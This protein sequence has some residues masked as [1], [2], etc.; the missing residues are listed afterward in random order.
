MAVLLGFHIILPIPVFL[1][2]I[3]LLCM[4][5]IL[6][7]FNRC[8][9]TCMCYVFGTKQFIESLLISCTQTWNMN[10]D[11][12]FSFSFKEMLFIITFA[13]PWL[14]CLGFNVLLSKTWI[15]MWRSKIWWYL[16]IFL[17]CDQQSLKVLSTT[18]WYSVP[19]S[20]TDCY[21]DTYP[22]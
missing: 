16:T 12:D 21:K 9:H 2:G 11:T 4:I 1:W 19:D 5:I 8:D 13:N 22:Y 18:G 15:V 20:L 7:V 17:L 6:N 10:Q 3:I 14:Y